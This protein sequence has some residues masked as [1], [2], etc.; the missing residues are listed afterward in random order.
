MSSTGLEIRQNRF[1]PGLF[2]DPTGGAYSTPPDPLGG[3]EGRGGSPPLLKNLSPFGPTGCAVFSPRNPPNIK[4]SYGLGHK[5]W[6]KWSCA[7]VPYRSVH[8]S[9]RLYKVALFIYNACI[10]YRHITKHLLCTVVDSLSPPRTLFWSQLVCQQ[11]LYSEF[12][13]NFKK[14]LKSAAASDRVLCDVILVKRF[15]ICSLT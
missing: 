13:M 3:G 5:R 12:S 7:Y 11:D 14:F 10:Y 4:P 6:C 2:P 8:L 9:Y 1:R 15:F